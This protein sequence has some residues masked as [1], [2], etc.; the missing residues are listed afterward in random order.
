L[1]NIGL[2]NDIIRELKNFGV[3]TTGLENSAESFIRVWERCHDDENRV[4]LSADDMD[5]SGIY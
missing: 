5:T 1:Q 2:E 3:D 4:K